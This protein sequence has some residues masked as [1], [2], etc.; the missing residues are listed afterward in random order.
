MSI[1]GFICKMQ[2]DTLNRA[3]PS[4][5]VLFVYAY[6][7]WHKFLSFLDFK[8]SLLL[9]K[10]IFIFLAYYA[11]NIIKFY[12]CNTNLSHAPIKSIFHHH[13]FKIPK[14]LF[15]NTRNNLN[16]RHRKVSC[17]RHKDRNARTI[18]V[19]APF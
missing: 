14:T 4:L 7:I 13:K 9:L 3:S 19:K 8:H 16:G 5:K 11:T 1:H 6:E 10:S 18:K 2:F 15:S 17:P 12:T